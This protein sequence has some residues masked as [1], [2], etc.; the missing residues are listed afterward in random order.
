MSHIIHDQTTNVLNNNSTFLPDTLTLKKASNTLSFIL[1]TSQEPYYRSFA[2]NLFPA[3]HSDETVTREV[4]D[5]VASISVW[6]RSKERGT[7]VKD[8]AWLLY[9]HFS[10]DQNRESRSSVF[11]CSKTKR[12]A[13]LRRLGRSKSLAFSLTVIKWTLLLI[14]LV[15]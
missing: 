11:L 7:R 3:P 5:C 2:L 4:L 13:F 14:T 12:K 1:A 15:P 8:R 10:L 6:F 9:F